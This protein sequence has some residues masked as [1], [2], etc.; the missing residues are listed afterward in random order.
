LRLEPAEGAERATREPTHRLFR[1][2]RSQRVRALVVDD[3]EDNREVLSGLL[4]RAGLE[5]TRAHDGAQA[6]QKIAQRRPDIVFMDVRMPVMDGVSAVRAIRD[7]WAGEDIVCVAITASGLLRPRSYYLEVGF[8]DFVGKPF[9]FETICEC[10]AK[11]LDIELAEAPAEE[12]SA[13]D[14]PRR[15]ARGAVQIPE[16]LRRR[17]LTAAELNAL[18][19]IER[20]I[21]ELKRLDAG[22][23]ELAEQLEGL[24][25]RYDT[26]G[27][28]ALVRQIPEA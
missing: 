25:S 7:R 17:L 18:T 20:L 22:C 21:E 14:E 19:E 3:V 26:D 11:H 27:I 8:D 23:R 10:M 5:V 12:A 6:L 13:S 1:L 24:L 15:S 9:R 28:S 4:E 16:P 2:A